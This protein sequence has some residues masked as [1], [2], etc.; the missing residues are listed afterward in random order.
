MLAEIQKQ[1]NELKRHRENLEEEVADRTTKLKNQQKAL[2]DALN[3]AEQLAVKAN[4]ANRAKTEFLAN[5]SHEIRTPL[6]AILGFTGLLDSLTADKKKKAYLRSIKSSGKNLLTLINDILDLS[7]IEAEK[8]EIHYEPVNPYSFFTEI[9]HIFSL[10]ISEKGID[11]IMD[12][13]SDIPASLLLDEVRL[14]QILF[15]LVGNAVKFTEKG[16]IKLVARRII[17]EYDENNIDLLIA[18]EDT[19]IGINPESFET[20]FEAFKQQEGQ[21]TKKYGGTGLG[22]AISKRLIE[23]MNGKISVQSRANQGSTF[24]IILNNVAIAETSAKP[25]KNKALDS[26]NISFE[27]A[28]LLLSEN[29]PL[30]LAKIPKIVSE[31][32][33]EPMKSWEAAR[34]NGLFDDIRHFANQV[35]EVGNKYSLEMLQKFGDDLILCVSSFDIE[36]IT[37]ALD[38]Y[39]ELIAKL[40][41]LCSE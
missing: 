6:N 24:A 11:F 20:I 26:G 32:E 34:Q 36:K 16:Y 35:K 9:E 37:P 41:L 30:T 5:M 28:T 40:K 23:M 10:S 1:E 25:H 13:S 18:V 8:M 22:L 19:G 39:P 27:K 33:D 12:I 21:S 2:Q 14:R 3:R 29:L 31:L 38:S 15:N 7:K 17:H 4:A